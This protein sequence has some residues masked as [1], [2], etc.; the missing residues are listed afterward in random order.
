MFV[1]RRVA[2]VLHCVREQI[3]EF[4]KRVRRQMLLAL[5]LASTASSA[6]RSATRPER[7]LG[8]RRPSP[9]RPLVPCYTLARTTALVPPYAHGSVLAVLSAH[10]GSTVCKRS[11]QLLLLVLSTA[12]QYRATRRAVAEMTCREVRFECGHGR[13]SCSPGSAIHTGVT[14]LVQYALVPYQT[15]AVRCALGQHWAQH[16]TQPAAKHV[17]IKDM[18]L[19]EA[20]G[21]NRTEPALSRIRFRGFRSERGLTDRSRSLPRC[22]LYSPTAHAE[23]SKDL[24]VPRGEIKHKPLNFRTQNLKFWWDAGRE[25]KEYP[26]KSAVISNC[27]VESLTARTAFASETTATNSPAG[28]PVLSAMIAREF[29]PAVRLALI[30]WYGAPVAE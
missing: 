14:V 12:G 19:S 1:L 13:H 26:S 6:T 21:R 8:A 29:S 11:V 20:F 9:F 16:T 17:Q 4:L 27:H 3:A 10:T 18:K 25:E 7:A 15:A 30:R 24:P 5:L 2:V 28:P 23:H 22:A